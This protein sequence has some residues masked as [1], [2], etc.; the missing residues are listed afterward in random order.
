MQ[1]KKL[2]CNG[3]MSSGPISLRAEKIA[4]QSLG[5]RG[6]LYWWP[7]LFDFLLCFDPQNIMKSQKSVTYS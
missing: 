3:E 2:I 1:F 6:K 5:E 4:L 7:C